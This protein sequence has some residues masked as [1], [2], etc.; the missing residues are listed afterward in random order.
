MCVF[1]GIFYYRCWHPRFELYEFCG[2]FYQ[3]LMR[4]NDPKQQEEFALPFSPYLP[5]C[6]PIIIKRKGELVFVAH[7]E[8]KMTN[9]VEWQHEYLHKCPVCEKEAAPASGSAS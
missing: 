6:D 7:D 4:I 1:K 3:Q 5:G 8:N 9:I 2:A